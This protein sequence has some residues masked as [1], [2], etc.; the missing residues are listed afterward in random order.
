MENTPP[1]Q[2]EASMETIACEDGS[3][4]SII[5]YAGYHPPLTTFITRPELAQQV[6]FVVYPPGGEIRRH[7]H[8]DN[9][10]VINGTSEAVWVKKGRCEIDVYDNQL[11][12]LASREL[13][14]GDFVLMCS[15]G[16]G[17]RILEHTVLLEVKLGPYAGANDKELF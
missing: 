9:P 15:G 2:R 12:L 5:I 14:P 3:I 8:K 10:R 13:N 7:I 11:R 4:A 1:L 16:H 17:F 6:G